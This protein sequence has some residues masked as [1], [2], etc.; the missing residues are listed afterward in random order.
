MNNIP[1]K[2]TVLI[3]RI[4]GIAKELHAL[5]AIQK[6][7]KKEL[8]DTDFALASFHLQRILEGVVNIGTH[9]LSRKP[10][11]GRNIT[12]YRDIAVAL[13]EI[14]I[15]PK[16]FAEKNLVKMVGYRNRLVHHYAEIS[17]E[18]ILKILKKN[19]G[20]IEQFLSCIKTLIK[21]PESLGFTLD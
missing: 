12:R 16:K 9:I 15:V 17:K 10:G 19:L 3:P 5:E 21:K 6:K 13:G 8:S 2:R 4:D 14:G 11:E 7:T 1:L 20:E 18:E